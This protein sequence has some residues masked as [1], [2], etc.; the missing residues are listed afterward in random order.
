M[1]RTDAMR[2]LYPY[3]HALGAQNVSPPT[4]R[5]QSLIVGTR[6]GITAYLT[7]R[8]RTVIQ[9][10]IIDCT[11]WETLEDPGEETLAIVREET[12]VVVC[13]AFAPMRKLVVANSEHVPKFCSASLCILASA[14]RADRSC[15]DTA[16]LKLKYCADIASN[17]RCNRKNEC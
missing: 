5:L 6:S 1:I 4:R 11:V 17:E 7:Q 13:S 15:N 3:V 2:E 14:S 12:D 9:L 8:Q 16:P 10:F